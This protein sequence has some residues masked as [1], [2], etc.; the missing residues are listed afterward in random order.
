M[1]LKVAIGSNSQAAKA[2]IT[3]GLHQAV[4]PV[5]DAVRLG[6]LL[7][8]L[9]DQLG[10]L[11]EVLLACWNSSWVDVVCFKGREEQFNSCCSI[12]MWTRKDAWDGKLLQHPKSCGIRMVRGIVKKYYDF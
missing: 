1:S 5:E 8:S 7:Q 3:I 10:N 6:D 4:V 12:R 11:E 2:E 9:K